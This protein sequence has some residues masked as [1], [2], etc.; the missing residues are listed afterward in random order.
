MAHYSMTDLSGTCTW[1]TPPEF[2]DKFKQA[3][4]TLHFISLHFRQNRLNA[5]QNSCHVKTETFISD[6]L[7][8]LKARFRFFSHIFSLK[9]TNIRPHRTKLKKQFTVYVNFAICYSSNKCYLWIIG[10]CSVFHCFWT[11][12]VFSFSLT[13]IWTA[14]L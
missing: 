13:K 10:S 1:Q 6:Q 2:L 5:G 3:E 7:C 8:Y 12:S 14:P 9:I 4:N 11:D